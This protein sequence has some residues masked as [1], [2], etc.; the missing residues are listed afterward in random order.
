[1]DIEKE[2]NDDSFRSASQAFA[3]MTAGCLGSGIV[4]LTYGM[5]MAGF[6]LGI[7]TLIICAIS[8]IITHSI[9]VVGSLEIGAVDLSSLLVRT[10][11][12]H[13]LRK[14]IRKRSELFTKEYLLA[15]STD[16]ILSNDEIS[17]MKSNMRFHF[18]AISIICFLSMAYALPV[19][20]ILLRSFTI[21]LLTHATFSYPEIQFLEY[22]KNE[23]ILSII[24]LFI[25]IPFSIRSK[26]SDLDFLGWFSVL[27]FFILVS[28]VFFRSIIIPYDGP[29]PPIMGPTTL[30]P[31]HGF[32]EASK[33]FSFAT[34]AFLCHCLV[35]PAV[36]NVKKCSSKR[37]IYVISAS[38]IFLLSFS[39]LMT[40]SA[41]YTFGEATMNNIT[42]NFSPCDN[43][44]G[45]SRILS[46]ISLCV[47]IPLFT[48]SLSNF[49]INDIGLINYMSELAIEDVFQILFKNRNQHDYTLCVKLSNSTESTMA[50]IYKELY[51]YKA[52]SL[53]S[54]ELISTQTDEQTAK[55]YRVIRSYRVYLSISILLIAILLSHIAKSCTQYV[56]LFCGYIDAFT[57][58]IYPI[59]VYYILWYNNKSFIINFIVIL[60]SMLSVIGPSLSSIFAT[61]EL[62]L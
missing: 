57:A 28:A 24:F 9:F 5:K 2:G 19:Y 36:L 38:M 3:T 17:E 40:I 50:F 12:L 55:V 52:R 45:F 31:S 4:F 47:I 29:M 18:K 7:F 14:F 33:M 58:A 51:K 60:F 21:D 59:F 48:I 1:M 34:Y 22:L 53:D 13:T 11:T 39:L 46:C 43:I 44:M 30:L 35:V 6:I 26:V 20:F 27:S 16:I 61:Y 8:A 49:I 10:S 32:F 56:E 37:C 15:N 62:F 42:Q 54:S 41:Y 25:V 23:Y